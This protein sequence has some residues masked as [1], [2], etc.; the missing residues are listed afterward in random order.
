MTL[1][2][3]RVEAE[4][5]AWV[6]HFVIG[7]NLCPFAKAVHARQQVRYVVSDAT[8]EDDL[9]DALAD[10]M[11][12]LVAT[13]A[14]VVDTTMLIHP[15]VLQDFLDFN[16]FL[17]LADDLVEELGYAGTLQVASFHPRY[18]F[19]DTSPDDPGNASNRS[20]YPVLHLLRED[21]VDR[22]VAAFPEAETIY[23]KNIRTLEELGPEGIAALQR[24]CKAD[25]D[26][27]DTRPCGGSS[28]QH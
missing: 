2:P 1:D 25:A 7:L 26:A 28:L 22:A 6:D 17:G 14:D 20:P 10:E 24:Q 23:E 12:R 15:L 8:T 13:D 19:A 16:D 3:A 27:A 21:S 9:L 11:H 5:R 4:T 18:Q